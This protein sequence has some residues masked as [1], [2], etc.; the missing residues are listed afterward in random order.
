MPRIDSTHESGSATSPDSAQAAA[1]R[2]QHRQPSSSSRSQQFDVPH[3]S[4]P[5]STHSRLSSISETESDPGIGSAPRKPPPSLRSDSVGSNDSFHSAVSETAAETFNARLAEA[6]EQLA[7]SGSV[8]QSQGVSPA[9]GAATSQASATAAVGAVAGLET[10]EGGQAIEM[11]TSGVQLNEAAGLNDGQQQAFLDQVADNRTVGGVAVAATVEFVAKAV[12]SGIHF[13]AVQ[14]YVLLAADDLLDKNG[15][16]DPVARAAAKA[17]LV[18]PPLAVAH[19]TAEVILR[20]AMVS[21]APRQQVPTD[22]KKAFPDTSDGF[23]QRRATMT[24]QQGAAKPGQPIGDMIGLASFML[25]NGVRAGAG[26]DNNQS[27]ILASAMGGGFMALGHTLVNFATKTRSAGGELVPSHSV[28]GAPKEGVPKPSVGDKVGKAVPG[29][30][31][32]T[33]KAKDS[34]GKDAD[35]LGTIGNVV[36]DIFVAREAG[37]TQ[38]E[39]IKE[40]FA[41]KTEPESPSFGKRFAAGAAGPLAILGMGFFPDSGAKG[42]ATNRG[43]T[44]GRFASTQKALQGLDPRKNSGT[45]RAVIGSED[46]DTAMSQV[47]NLL[48]SVIDGSHQT[49]TSFLRLPASVAIDLFKVAAE[50]PAAYLNPFPSESGSHEDSLHSNV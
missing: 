18:G 37:L 34:A 25:A 43:N 36:H 10:V 28:A 48:A 30:L 35:G 4:R 15:V 6:L 21:A 45:T 9:A 22:A 20:T 19:Y 12:V 39:F 27:N 5:P 49:A 7:N 24:A 32:A 13:G 50:V 31:K 42:L 46:L 29:A 26:G 1:D 40:M 33:S 16:H 44:A 17:A 11:L 38:G 23:A 2:P 8:S 3:R 41:S 14:S 47:R